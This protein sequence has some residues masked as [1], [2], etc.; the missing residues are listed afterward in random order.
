MFEKM[1]LR[2]ADDGPPYTLGDIAEAL[3]YYQNVHLILDDGTLRSLLSQISGDE[4]SQLLSRQGVSA[5]Y[6]RSVLA[7]HTAKI[8]GIEQHSFVG[9]L[10]V[11]SADG[12]P[13]E[14]NQDH[15]ELQLQRSGMA[16]SKSVRLAAKLIRKLRFQDQF[17]KHIV[18]GGLSKVATDDVF[19]EAYITSATH[20]VIREMPGYTSALTLSKVDVFKT[21]S[22]F[23]AVGG[24]DLA[25]FNAQRRRLNPDMEPLTMAYLLGQVASARADLSLAAFYGGDFRTSSAFSKLIQLRSSELLRRTG[26]NLSELQQFQEIVLDDAPSLREVIDGGGRSFS[27]LMTLLDKSKLFKFWTNAQSPDSNLTREYFKEAQREGWLETLP[28]KGLRYLMGQVLSAKLPVLG[29]L[30]SVADSFLLEK[31]A[32]GWRP[33]HFVDKRYKPFVSKVSH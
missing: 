8:G 28:V 2:R 24:V 4:I 15:L 5:T 6:L 20:E 10:T 13:I 3:L 27:E 12:K 29:E 16:K 30:F 19:D 1:I 7:V 14:S 11:K 22:G 17:S 23:H 26:L 18:P 9:I 25:E 21:E 33:S 31:M 32:K